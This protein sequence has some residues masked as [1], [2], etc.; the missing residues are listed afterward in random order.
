MVNVYRNQKKKQVEKN[1]KGD[2]TM[3]GYYNNEKGK[4]QI[5][6]LENLI[7]LGGF[8]KEQIEDEIAKIYPGIVIRATEKYCPYGPGFCHVADI[9]EESLLE[10]DRYRF[11]NPKDFPNRLFDE[12]FANQIA[13]LETEKYFGEKSCL[14]SDWDLSK[15]IRN[16]LKQLNALEERVLFFVSGLSGQEEMSVSQIAELPE[17]DCRPEF[18]HYIIKAIDMAFDDCTWGNKEFIE[19]CELYK[20]K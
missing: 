16:A 19:S 5:C 1:R 20:S 7:S 2:S 18:I 3:L 14:W 13:R 8:I 4:Q 10:N 15:E 9:V 12:W 6:G 17:F 11:V